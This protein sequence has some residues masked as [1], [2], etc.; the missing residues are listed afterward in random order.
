MKLFACDG[1]GGLFLL[2]VDVGVTNGD[3]GAELLK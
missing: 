2:D 1:D 3:V